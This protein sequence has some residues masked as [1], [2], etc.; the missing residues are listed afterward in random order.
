MHVK[1][2]DKVSV[3]TGE[4]RGA[5]GTVLKVLPQNGRVV[6]EGVNVL[7]KH[8]KGKRGG[9]KGQIVEKPFSIHASNV[10]K[11]DPSSG[12]GARTKKTK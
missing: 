6:I 11:V 5:V 9:Q 1:K 4:N 8:E 10:L 3:L 7:K 2:G 12:K